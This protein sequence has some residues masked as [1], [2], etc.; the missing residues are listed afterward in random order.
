MEW[1]VKRNKIKLHKALMTILQERE[2]TYPY[3]EFEP[4]HPEYDRLKKALADYR[5][6]QRNG[7]WPTL[8]AGAKLR[9][10]D[11]SPVVALLRKRLLDE[12][13]TP[14]Q[15]VAAP[16]QAVSAGGPGAAPA[17]QKYDPELVGAVKK[18]QRLT[19]L[20]PD[21]I[22][23]GNTLRMLNIP[24]DERIDQIILNMERWRWIP[25]TAGERLPAGEHSRLQAARCS[26]RPGRDG[27]GRHRGQNHAR[28]A[29][30][31]R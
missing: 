30:I 12:A 28:H 14:T 26:G 20:H 16:V 5:T 31:Q 2:S 6:I 3:Y 11:A 19:G 25:K 23:A 24:L 1:D 13:G 9:P 18:F 15:D 10:G 29:G 22:V 17:A 21:G 4:L 27:H 8:P 7:G